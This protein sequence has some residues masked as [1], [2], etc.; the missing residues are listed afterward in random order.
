MLIEDIIEAVEDAFTSEALDP[1]RLERFIAFAVKY[2]SRYN[3]YE[4]ADTLSLVV[5]QQDYD[6]AADCVLVKD[7][8]YWPAG[9]VFGVLRTGEE[10]LVRGQRR[11][12]FPSDQVIDNIERTALADRQGPRW[13]QI[14]SRKVRL[15]PAPT[16]AD[17][18]DY[19]YY[20]VHTLD[21]GGDEYP[22]IPDEDIEII[23]DLV[24][25]EVV[26]SRGLEVTI[27]PDYAEGLQRVTKGRIPENVRVAVSR[28]RQGVRDKYGSGVVA[29]Q[30]SVA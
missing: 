16:A 12:H 4:E 21:A 27:E 26:G 2:Y 15:Y 29:M 20:A 13:E 25:A 24:L 28:L 3:P 17:T 19:Q 14:G 11:Y 10:E 1:G 7:V 8:D 18:A 6:V 30:G 9:E 5:G 22:T 23:R